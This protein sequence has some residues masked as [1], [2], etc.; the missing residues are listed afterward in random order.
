MNNSTYRFTLD[1]QKHNSQMS[2]AVYKY[3]NAVTLYIG[4]TD[5]GKSYKIEPGCYAIFYGKRADG[6]A[7]IH[8][9]ELKD[10]AELI[11]VFRNST[12]YV[13]GVVDCQIR[14]YDGK[15]QLIT[16]PRF[17]IMVE[18][19][20]IDED[21]IKIEDND[22][23]QGL[24][25]IFNNENNRQLKEAAR[26]IA[27]NGV[28]DQDGNL[29]TPGRVQAE[30]AREQA[31]KERKSVW[32][33]YSAHSDGTSST[34]KWREGQNYIGVATSHDKPT[35][36]SQYAWLLF[37]GTK[38]DKGEKGESG[39]PFRIVKQY[40]SVKE[41]REDF[42]NKA[43]PLG[44]FVLIVTGTPEVGD[45]VKLYCK[46][47]TAWTY[48]S[49]MT[50][51]VGLKGDKGEAGDDGISATHKWDG[52][53]LTITSAT[54]TSSADLKGDKGNPGNSAFQIAQ[55]YGYKGTEQEWVESLKG[56]PGK[57]GSSAYEIAQ[58]AGFKGSKEEWVESLNGTNGT[59]GKSAYQIACDNTGFKG[60]ADEWVKSLNGKDGKNG[61]D[62]RSAFQIAQENGYNGDDEAAWVQSLY[63]TDGTDGKSAYEIACDYHP[64]ASE[65]EWLASLHGKDGVDGKS[66]YEIA[67]DYDSYASE[68]EW[69]ASLNGTDGKSAYEIA[70][71]RGFE[72]NEREWIDSLSARHEWDGT[73]LKITSANGTSSANLKGDKGNSAYQVA[74]I[75]GFKGTEEEWLASLHGV[76]AEHSWNG[77]TL[78]LTSASG[79]S[80]ADLKGD[81]GK[82][83]YQMAC[84]DGFEGTEEEWLRYLNGFTKQ[85]MTTKGEQMRVFVGEQAEYDALSEVEKSN[86]FALITD[87]TL[88]SDKIKALMK[89]VEDI[90]NGTTSVPKADFASRL[91]CTVIPSG[92]DVDGV[93]VEGLYFLR[94]NYGYENLP[95]GFR[96][97]WLDVKNKDENN[98]YVIQTL[99]GHEAT[100]WH[101]HFDGEEWSQWLR[102]VSA[103]ELT[104]YATKTSLSSY[105][106]KTSLS[107][108]AT[109]TDLSSY[110]TKNEVVGDAT[111]GLEYDSSTCIGSG[112]AKNEKYLTIAP[113][114]DGNRIT[115]IGTDAFK[116][117]TSLKSVVLPKYL[118]TIGTGAFEYCS[119]LNEVV[120]NKALTTINQYAFNGCTSLTEIVL[121]DS[122]LN[123]YKA[124]FSNC[125]NLRS[126]FIPANVGIIEMYAFNNC[127]NLTIYCEDT[128]KPV[129]WHDNWNS[130]NCPVVWGAVMVAGKKCLKYDNPTSIE[131]KLAA[132]KGY[133]IQA[134]CVGENNSSMLETMLL[135]ISDTNGTWYSSKSAHDCFCLYD[136]TSIEFYYDDGIEPYQPIVAYIR[137]I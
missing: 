26:D 58:A 71:S 84:E 110:A 76:S 74:C 63:G 15:D 73:T 90:V 118:T 65:T 107:D 124:A 77:T 11:Y 136:G 4:L 61:A 9:C 112:T 21:D 47:E 35:D 67:S 128:S 131:I 89:T 68:A 109:K 39:E 85:I 122:C 96:S 99:L 121:P 132:G 100:E 82:S 106:T 18:E 137:E 80:S 55:V 72:G 7:L 135:F 32:V 115:A 8:K 95:D 81:T 97:G 126:I 119:Y 37:K 75:N 113:I 59:D 60:S 5:G 12:A 93:Y 17:T 78:T 133:I 102:C 29:V 25:D 43:V 105:A 33:R 52:T 41:M 83:A 53:K 104:D 3:D 36:N 28:F 127:P 129:G 66:A 31:E 91:S 50:V 38:G 57:N 30:E 69:L 44:S 1:L 20:V 16:A 87:E 2:I 10:S 54:G 130:G 51:D 46:G 111:Q 114:Y 64:Y 62:G 24:D 13:G 98:N 108:Y 70:K 6:K 48:I 23:L 45:T 79:T 123:I 49:D 116:N 103:E 40:T 56:E 94:Y 120:F 14:I 125:T 134:T 22:A 19:R 88:T 117:H 92:V 42:A 101:R 86:L 34:E 27:E